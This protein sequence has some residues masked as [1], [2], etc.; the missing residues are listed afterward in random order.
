MNDDGRRRDVHGGARTGRV[1]LT[2][3]AGMV[4]ELMDVRVVRES[5]AY[6]SRVDTGSR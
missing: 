1:F 3:E 2:A 4:C 5:Y 6:G